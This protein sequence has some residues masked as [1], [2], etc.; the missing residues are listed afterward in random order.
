M[1]P[2]IDGLEVAVGDKSI[3]LI[4]LFSRNVCPCVYMQM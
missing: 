3:S 4:C 1:I 2:N